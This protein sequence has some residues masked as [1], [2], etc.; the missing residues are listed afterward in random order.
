MGKPGTAWTP[1]EDQLVLSS[2]KSAQELSRELQRS[3]QA[4]TGRR[5]RLRNPGTAY[6]VN[7]RWRK[8]HPDRRRRDKNRHYDTGEGPKHNEYQSW[9]QAED[10]AITASNRPTDRVLAVQLGR[11]VRAIQNRRNVVKSLSIQPPAAGQQTK[12]K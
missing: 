1:E 9:G 6:Q 12:G 8:N 5:Y 4:I 10:R 3:P 2:T 11:T 7:K